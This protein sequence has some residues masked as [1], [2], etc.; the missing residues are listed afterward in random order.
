MNIDNFLF[1]NLLSVTKPARYIG[2]E[3]NQ[4]K[5]D[6]DKQKIRFA[7]C[8]PDTYEIGMSNLGLKIIYG[9]L[10]SLDRVVCER[11]F[12]VWSDFEELLLK[13]SLE[14]FSLE[15][16]RALREFDIIGFS[17]SHELSY[18]NVLNILKLGNIAL[19]SAERKDSDPLVIAGGHACF[20]PEPMADFIDAF[21]IGEAE[22]IILEIIE[23][24]EK[25]RDDRAGLLGELASLEGVY[26]P[27]L[28]KPQ[29]RV[30]RRIINDFNNAYYPVN[31]IVP[32]INIV[33][34]RISIEIMRGC[35]G[36]C[37]FCHACMVTRP[38]RLRDKAKVVELVKQAYDLT[39]YEE[40]SLV[41]LSSADHPQI[42]EMMTLLNDYFK[43]KGINI[44]LPSL[45]VESALRDLP[46][47]IGKTKKT[48]LTFALEAATERLRN[49]INKNIRI[50]DLFSVAMEAFKA[51]WRHLKLYFMIGLPTETQEDIE[52]IVKLCRE[53]SALKKKI[54][55]HP[56]AINITVSAF[57]PKPHTSFQWEKMEDIEVLKRRAGFIRDSLKSNLFKVDVHNIESSFLE[58]VFSRGD[59]KLGGV[60]LTA[61]N[62]G[63][64]F[65]NWSDR[66]NFKTWIDA[67]QKEGIDPYVY[68]GKMSFDDTLSW[69]I[70]DTGAGRDFLI[71]ENKL[72]GSST[73]SP[74]CEVN[75]CRNS[76]GACVMVGNKI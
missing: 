3:I 47:L 23:V 16:K 67:F 38:V 12:S 61:F 5:K 46:A 24:F 32:Y 6:F 15:S 68:A 1:D 50:E 35:T 30:K 48:T 33:H 4:V 70:I 64:R 49:V 42:K 21:V 9:I 17:I 43:G 39:G 20:N 29:K 62:S 8:F 53:L 45:R 58:A 60:I 73:S 10:N 26:V 25:H 31:Q 65:D 75:D 74:G 57:I 27:S 19:K 13:N 36:G 11:V 28:G 7:L 63:C 14:I 76:C 34:D 44:S 56:A 18:T 55:G 52:G 54:D 71:K 40:I 72:A 66:F 22:E 51:G 41:S 2:R 59:R 37:R 69:D